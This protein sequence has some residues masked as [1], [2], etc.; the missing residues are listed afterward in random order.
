MATIKIGPANDELKTRTHILVN[1]MLWLVGTARNSI[2]VLL[3][4]TLA[5]IC[6]SNGHDY[7]H[8]I[9]TIPAGLPTVE[10]PQFQLAELRNET[11]GEIIRPA[12][13]F[14]DIVAGMGSG[15]IV[16]PL[17]TLLEDIAICKAFGMY[18]R[19]HN[20]FI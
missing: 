18:I 7:F 3:S 5:F 16:I 20:C 6:T 11:S 8:L 12:E 9:G 17:I 4:G 15:L 10:I 14:L 13:S 19:T 2:L 1:K